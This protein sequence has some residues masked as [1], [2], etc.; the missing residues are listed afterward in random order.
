MQER[1]SEGP[2]NVFLPD[3]KLQA[4]PRQGTMEAAAFGCGQELER[5][6]SGLLQAQRAVK[7]CVYLSY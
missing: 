4:R 3:H 7:L 1:L 5:G 2:L 6:Q